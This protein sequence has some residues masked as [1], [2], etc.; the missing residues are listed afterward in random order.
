MAK[1]PVEC[2]WQTKFGGCDRTAY[3]TGVLLDAQA[4]Q[5][6]GN[7]LHPDTER[8]L[9]QQARHVPSLAQ[10]IRGSTINLRCIGAGDA[11]MQ[12]NCDSYEPKP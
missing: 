4:T 9:Q 6:L 1:L 11:N 2:R 10:S 3:A 7:W 5:H 8:R 12:Q